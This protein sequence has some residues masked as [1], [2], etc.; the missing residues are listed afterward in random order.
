MNANSRLL[1]A[2]DIKQDKDFNNLV[3]KYYQIYKVIIDKMANMN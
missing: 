3:K 1:P 2:H